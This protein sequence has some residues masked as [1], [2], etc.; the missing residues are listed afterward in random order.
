MPAPDLTLL[1]RLGE[2]V[3]HE[4]RA[5]AERCATGQRKLTLVTWR[6]APPAATRWSIW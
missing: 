1:D 2:L 6:S 5:E 4:R 3:E